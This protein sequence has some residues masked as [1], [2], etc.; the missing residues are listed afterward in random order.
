MAR[1]FENPA[2]KHR[3][4]VD[5][6]ASIAVFFFG[7]L[8]LA[9]KGLWGHVFIW[10]VIVVPMTIATGGPG[11]ILFL[12]LASI[13]YAAIIQ[14]IVSNSYLKKGWMELHEVENVGPD[15]V[16]DTFMNRSVAP[17]KPEMKR[18]PFCAEDVKYEAVKCKHC[19]S[20]LSFA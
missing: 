16:T 19:Q 7:V 4:E 20:D 17:T 8:Y 5:S 2:N 10:L 9:I 14:G 15:L 13:I 6:G 11:L 3:E 1:I 12:P 18:C